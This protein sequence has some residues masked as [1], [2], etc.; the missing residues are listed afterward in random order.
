M[1]GESSQGCAYFSIA[2]TKTGESKASSPGSARG[3][4]AT[5]RGPAQKPG[6]P[7]IESKV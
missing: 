5:P 4:P 6:T 2:S 1:K 3:G 7:Q